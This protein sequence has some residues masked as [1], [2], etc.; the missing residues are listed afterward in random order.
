MCKIIRSEYWRQVRFYRDCLRVSCGRCQTGRN[1]EKLYRRCYHEAELATES[2]WN[3]VRPLLPKR[4]RHSSE[5][6]TFINLGDTPILRGFNKRYAWD[7]GSTWSLP[8]V[9]L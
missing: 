8:S 2:L 5:A 4:G 7:R 9:A 6:G 1:R 3:A